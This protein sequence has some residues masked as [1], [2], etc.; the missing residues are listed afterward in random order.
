MDWDAAAC[1]AKRVKEISHILNRVR[2]GYSVYA[3]STSEE[4]RFDARNGDDEI[5]S[6]KTTERERVSL[7]N[8]LR[9]LA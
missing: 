7:V 1:G 4:M 8:M 3:P 6:K 9:E 2:V 5:E